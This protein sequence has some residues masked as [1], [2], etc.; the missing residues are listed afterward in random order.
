MFNMDGIIHSLASQALA[1][2][3]PLK[4]VA[5]G[6]ISL[7]IHRVMDTQDNILTMDIPT[8]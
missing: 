2:V 5:P 3:L 4:M 8:L 6:D 1:I 7:A